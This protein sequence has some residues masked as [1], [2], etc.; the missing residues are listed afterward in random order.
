MS[1]NDFKE[2]FGLRAVLDFELFPVAGTTITVASLLLFGLI[3][4]LAAI[5]SSLLGRALVRAAKLRGVEREGTLAVI[6]RLLHYFVM[7]VGF[8]IGLETI[9]IQ[10]SA[11]FAA[12]AVFAIGL[13]FAM[14]NITQNF[15]SGLI[16]LLERTIKPGDVLFVDGRMVR[17]SRMGIRAT[18]ARTLDDEELIVP[19]SIIVQ[20]SVTNYTL[21]DTHYRLRT[22]VGVSYASDMRQVRDVL[23]KAS[24]GIAWRDSGRDS[25]V[26]LHG[27]GTS[28]V[29]WE[30]SVWIQDP[31]RMQALRSQLNEVVWFALKDAGITIAFPQLDVH[32]DPAVAVTARG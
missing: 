7:A 21:Q 26:L 23:E 28:S 18:Q 11:L 19:N 1:A 16:I 12:G 27:F 5:V 14:Q 8:G 31:W 9:G 17:V 29:D 20:N 13:G 24:A 25:V 15:V 10:M 2:A 6:R 30:V 32:F 22:T 4:L 3:V